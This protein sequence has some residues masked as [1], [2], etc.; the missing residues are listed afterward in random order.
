M[1]DLLNNLPAPIENEEVIEEGFENEMP[2]LVKNEIQE[3]YL[4][5]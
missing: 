4:R 5:I 1:F 3:T 2:F